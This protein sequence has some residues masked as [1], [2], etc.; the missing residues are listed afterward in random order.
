MRRVRLVRERVQGAGQYVL[1]PTHLRPPRLPA[2]SPKP[3]GKLGGPSPP[4]DQGV[5]DPQA[6]TSASS[7]NISS[8]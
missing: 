8:P 5:S 7:P 1:E 2:Y 4:G 6:A 3:L